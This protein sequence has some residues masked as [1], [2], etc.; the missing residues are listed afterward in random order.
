M[1]FRNKVAKTPCIPSYF[2]GNQPNI[3]KQKNV[4]FLSSLCIQYTRVAVK[5]TRHRIRQTS[6]LVITL[7]ND[8]AKSVELS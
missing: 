3:H 4:Q 1:Y 7:E 8:R 5:R 6:V 2:K